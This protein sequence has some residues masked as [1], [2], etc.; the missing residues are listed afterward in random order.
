MLPHGVLLHK[1]KIIN[2]PLCIHCA[3][4]ETLF[5]MLVNCTVIQKFG[6]EVISWWKNHNGE[7]LLID[8]LSIM[9]G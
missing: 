8:D 9:Y 5:H 4:F 2:S 6:S 1:M 3:S 7:C